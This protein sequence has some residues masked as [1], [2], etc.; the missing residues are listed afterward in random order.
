MDLLRHGWVRC[1]F[2][3]GNAVT[4]PAG[5]PSAR[6]AYSM[7][8][9]MGPTSAARRSLNPSGEPQPRAR[10]QLG[11]VHPRRRKNPTA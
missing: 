5:T 9:A 2:V 1:Q 4:A 10:A 3:G 11:A 6:R 7:S 8:L